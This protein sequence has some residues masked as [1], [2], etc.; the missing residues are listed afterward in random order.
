[1]CAKI[2][3]T[4][5]FYHA[6]LA[7]AHYSRGARPPRVSVGSA[8]TISQRSVAKVQL[9]HGPGVLTPTPAGHTRSPFL[10]VRTE[11]L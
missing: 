2:T 1:M 5:T 10:P 3:T 7:V 11:A 6:V 8:G 9:S 4:T